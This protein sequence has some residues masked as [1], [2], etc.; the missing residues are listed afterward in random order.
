MAAHNAAPGPSPS[1]HTDGNLQLVYMTA[2]IVVAVLGL[3]LLH[4]LGSLRR[5]TS[6]KLLHAVVLGAY[7]LSYA[8]VS[9]TLGLMQES[10]DY[11]AEFPVWAVCL[12]MLLGGTDNLMACKLD[13]VDNWK[14]FHVKHLLKGTLVVYI[15]AAYTSRAP[16]YR[17]PLW[18]ILSVNVFQSC[19]RINSMKMASK[20]NLLAKNVKPIVDYMKRWSN[21]KIACAATMEGCTYVVAGEHRLSNRGQQPKDDMKITTVEQIWQSKG[22]LLRPDTERAMRLKDVCLSMALS[23]LLNRRFAAFKTPETEL[24]SAHDFV[25]KG[26]LVPWAGDKGCERVSDSTC[27]RVSDSTCERIFRVIEVELGFVYDLYY[28]RYPYLYHKVRHLALCLPVAM[29]IFC[30][31]LTYV[32]FKKHHE[33]ADSVP[34]CTTLYLMSVVTFLEAFQLY[35]HVASDWFKVALI[36]S[37]VTRPALQESVIW[38]MIISLSLRLKAFRPWESKL[39]Q[40]CLLQSYDGTRR[41]SNFIHYVTLWL[42]D[43]AKRGCK[44]GKLV[45]LS[46]HAKKAIIDSLVRRKEDLKKGMSRVPQIDPR[47]SLPLSLPCDAS[48]G[49]VTRTILV[50]HIATT[51]CK[52]KF[53][54][55][56][57]THGKQTAPLSQEDINVVFTASSLSQYCAYLIAFVPDLLPDH[58]F[59]SASILDKCIDE[60]RNFKPLQDAKTMEKKV[61]ELMSKKETKRDDAPRLNKSIEEA[62]NF[63]P[64]QG[65]KTMEKKCQELMSKETKSGDA[66]RLFI[67]GAQLATQ[68]MDI[69]DRWKVLSDFWA[70]MMI[71]IAP[72]EDAKARA[73]LEAL[74]RGGEFITHLWALLTHA[75]VLENEPMPKSEPTGLEAV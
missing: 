59:D 20:S 69:Q 22:S 65:A 26:L 44:R 33:E 48:N 11:F 36:R 66:P 75:G 58:N 70:E 29:V 71:Y 5:R 23:K 8:L 51:I 14:S 34:L 9:Y 61:H 19:M 73:H 64:L 28:T 62:H 37:Y 56:P 1:P 24:S 52:H 41:R 49:T 68:L 31:W 6:D 57:A 15:V 38:S 60:A 21:Q 39:G 7:T 74:A 10:T 55:A 13:D 4:V 63:K 16:E 40:Y 47:L 3:F 25:F 53:D 32:I 42:V 27:E 46:T 72:C 67:E 45:K 2:L 43:R 54:A 17:L 30:S 12:L 35:L 50:W 18:A